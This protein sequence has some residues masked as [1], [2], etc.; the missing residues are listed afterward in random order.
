[1]NLKQIRKEKGL[2]QE[3]IAQLLKINRVQVSN[4]ERG[5]NKLNEEQIVKLCIALNTSA[6]YFLGLINEPKTLHKE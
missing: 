2:K 3:E 6:D 4:Y 5:I 1:M